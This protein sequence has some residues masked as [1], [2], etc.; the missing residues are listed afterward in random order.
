LRHLN[1]AF[2]AFFEGRARYPTFEK[3]RG[4]QAADYTTSAFHWDAETRSPT[5]ATMDAPLA[6]VWS[7]AFA[8][9]PT[10]V[11]IP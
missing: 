6:I 2:R 8:G 10:T 4:G 9:A 7:R 3:K 1:R 11:T 5:F